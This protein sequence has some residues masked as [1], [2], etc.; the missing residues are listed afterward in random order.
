MGYNLIVDEKCR[1]SE[2]DQEKTLWVQPEGRKQCACSSF[3]LHISPLSLK[4]PNRDMIV[5]D[6]KQGLAET[7]LF[8]LA[9]ES[10]DV[11]ETV[12]VQATYVIAKK[13]ESCV[14]EWV[15][16]ASRNAIRVDELAAA[17]LKIAVKGEGM[18]KVSNGD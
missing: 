1:L 9:E 3:S 17:M 4:Y 8:D 13:S 2:P 15:V 11:F 6:T 12:I 7:K 10:R 16:G 5:I 18:G 14:P